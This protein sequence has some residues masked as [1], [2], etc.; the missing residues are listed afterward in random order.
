MTQ[1]RVLKAVTVCAFLV[2]LM[3]AW[4]YKFSLGG[5]R[6][7]L[8]SLQKGYGANA[9]VFIALFSVVSLVSMP[10]FGFAG[11]AGMVLSRRLG[12]SAFILGFL[13]CVLSFGNLML[14]KKYGGIPSHSK[15]E[16]IQKVYRNA[17]PSSPAK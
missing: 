1:L 15:P 10:I 5:Y 17:E 14:W 8:D 2:L 11:L 9:Y 12:R 7:T 6:Q 13:C 16:G 4:V 3:T